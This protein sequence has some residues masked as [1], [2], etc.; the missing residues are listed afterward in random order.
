MSNENQQLPKAPRTVQLSNDPMEQAAQAKDAH[1]AL[2]LEFTRYLRYRS[3][4]I[5]LS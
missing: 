5:G 2:S 1:M 4:N 3:I